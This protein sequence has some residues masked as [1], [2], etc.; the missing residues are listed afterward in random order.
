MSEGKWGSAA[1]NAHQGPTF[2]DGRELLG[3]LRS[4]ST[5]STDRIAFSW[6]QSVRNATGTFGPVRWCREEVPRNDPETTPKRP[7]NDPKT[8]PHPETTP[9]RPENDPET[10]PKRPQNDPHPRK[11]R[12][13]N[14]LKPTPKRPPFH[15]IP[16]S[17]LQRE[18]SGMSCL[19]GPC[20][21]FGLREF[22]CVLVWSERALPEKPCNTHHCL[23][24]PSPVETSHKWGKHTR[25]W[26]LVLELLQCFL[27][28]RR[29]RLEEQLLDWNGDIVVLES[30]NCIV[31]DL[32]QLVQGLL[33][34]V[35]AN[36]DDVEPHQQPQQGARASLVASDCFQLW[37]QK[38]K[39]KRANYP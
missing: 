24:C 11:H 34:Q 13:Q 17:Q 19:I 27:Q 12:C 9:K 18:L 39:E 32:L 15:L 37:P 23:L 14:D 28:L 8:T 3:G 20:W 5:E 29:P 26:S 21:A 6:G 10:T 22:Q 25:N 30:S 1:C 31:V 33:P 35:H 7:Q 36:Q 38:W 4:Q 16:P 2:S